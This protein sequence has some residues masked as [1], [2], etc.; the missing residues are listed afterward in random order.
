MKYCE[1]ISKETNLRCRKPISEEKYT[2]SITRIK[3]LQ[4][5]ETKTSNLYNL[6]LYEISSLFCKLHAEQRFIW[7]LDQLDIKVSACKLDFLLL[8]DRQKDNLQTS[9]IYDDQYKVYAPNINTYM[10]QLEVIRS[11]NYK[12]QLILIIY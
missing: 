12:S 4:N 7:Y 9:N 11:R 5:E 8:E 6:V 1:G 10:Q 2:M 3:E